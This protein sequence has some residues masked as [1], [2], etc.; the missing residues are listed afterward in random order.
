MSTHKDIKKIT[1][2]TLQRMKA[3]GEKIS[4]I[5]AYDFSFARIIDGDRIAA[6]GVHHLHGRDVGVAVAQEDHPVEG[7][8]AVLVGRIWRPEL[9]GPAVVVLRG[10]ELVDISTIAP[11]MRDL[12]EVPEPA[13]RE[14]LGV[15][16]R[17]ER[18]LVF[19]T[20]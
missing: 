4:M 12:C 18:V 3:N 16:N 14:I 2:N 6:L 20:Q 11:T 7:H 1:T 5:T 10:V 17:I 13:A 9:D 19:R 8:R 15:S